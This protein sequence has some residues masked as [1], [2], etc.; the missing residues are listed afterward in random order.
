MTRVYVLTAGWETQ[1]ILAVFADEA[2]ALR[3]LSRLE[4]EWDR[5]DVLRRAGEVT[6]W[7]VK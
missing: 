1:H 2:A 7:V 6:E 4:D 3:A 5:A